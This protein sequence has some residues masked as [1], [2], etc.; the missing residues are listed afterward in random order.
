MQYNSLN[1]DCGGH[2]ITIG[3]MYDFKLTP[4]PPP[5]PLPLIPIHVSMTLLCPSITS[6]LHF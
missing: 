4:P 5:P 6:P 2:L 1:H 3:Q